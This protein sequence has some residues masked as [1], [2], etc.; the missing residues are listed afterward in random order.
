M[1]SLY[2]INW[3]LANAIELYYSGVEDVVDEETGE[4]KNLEDYIAEV[5]IA[6]DDKV[7]GCVLYMKNLMAEEKAIKAEM[8]ALKKRATAKA[9]ERTKMEDY[10]RSICPDK[11]YESP[12]FCLKFRQSE[13]TVAPTS[14]EEIMK[15]PQEF[16]RKTEEY[17]VDKK[18]VKKAIQEGKKLPGCR[19][20]VKRNLSY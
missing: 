9:K 12:K 4:V 18:A 13:V 10:I 7:E 17:S 8:D 15:L 3:Q 20:D 14:Y 19:I 5:Q 2:E 16:I 6:F 11:K 1:S